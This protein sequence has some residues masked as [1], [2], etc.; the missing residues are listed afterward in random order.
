MKKSVLLLLSIFLVLTTESYAQEFNI[1]LY[2]YNNTDSIDF[3]TDGTVD[4]KYHP[5]SNLFNS[6]AT[7]YR[8]YATGTYTIKEDTLIVRPDSNSIRIVEWRSRQKY[9]FTEEELS[10]TRDFLMPKFRSEMK[11]VFDYDRIRY[12]GNWVP[13]FNGRRTLYIP[14]GT[15]VGE[16]KGGLPDGYGESN[17][18][19]TGRAK[20][21]WKRGLFIEGEA[22]GYNIGDGFYTG[23]IKNY[24]MDGEGV[25]YMPRSLSHGE[26][27]Y[28]GTFINGVFQEDHQ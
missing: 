1:G 4:I 11:M 28:R 16:V 2:V 15:Y 14:G 6:S 20:G 12:F 9:N 24:K 10:A 18:T 25:L 3:K 23:Y 26:R 5:V 17:S 7:K 21:I 13:R 8:V 19:K 22:E 27:E